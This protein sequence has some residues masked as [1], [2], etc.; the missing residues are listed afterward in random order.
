[1]PRVGINQCLQMRLVESFSPYNVYMNLKLLL[2]YFGMSCLQASEQIASAYA[3]MRNS[4]AEN[5]VT[6]LKS[7]SS[8]CVTF[9]A[10]RLD[11]SC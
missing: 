9:D 3:E 8:L 1:M 4:S 7:F 11:D 6:L 2:N 5:K 10:Q